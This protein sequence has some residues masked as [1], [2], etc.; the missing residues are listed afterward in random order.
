MNKIRNPIIFKYLSSFVLDITC[1]PNYV[2][3]K[4]YKYNF[5]NEYFES[6]F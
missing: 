3:K 5:A 4:V 6:T 2:L 1:L